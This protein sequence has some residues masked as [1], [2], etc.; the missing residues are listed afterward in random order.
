M[1]AGHNAGA[2]MATTI[3][4]GYDTDGIVRDT[5]SGTWTQTADFSPNQ[6]RVEFHFTDDDTWLDGDNSSDETGNDANQTAIVY[7]MDGNV[8]AS[9][10]VYSEEYYTLEGPGGEIIY[11]DR[12][13][14]GGVH[15]GYVTSAPLEPG[16]TYT[17]TAVNN[18]TAPDAEEYMYLANVPCFGAGTHLLTPE[19]EVPVD[20]LA[21]GDRLVTRDNGVQP[22]LW[23]GRFRVSVPQ[24]LSRPQLR[25]YR[26]A[27][28][29]LGPGQPTHDM[30]LSA[31][32]RVLLS[33]YQVELHAGTEEVLA[34]VAHLG[35]SGL[36]SS[37]VPTSDFIFTHV[38]LPAHE[39][40]MANGMWVESLF[41]GEQV[42]PELR[43]RL[44][45]R[46]RRGPLPPG[47]LQTARR[48]LKQHEVAAIL[49]RRASDHLP[50]L[51]RATG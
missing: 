20:W 42:D 3:N 10:Q 32:H 4:I 2:N 46:Y 49:G 19:G 23:V 5:A 29:A 47:H 27:R 24:A 37:E 43:S 34:A 33:G 39:V 36:F 17:E 12:I 35:D 30:Q 25:P 28:D 6:H 14:I 45:D 51:L 40:V 31:Q 38:L 26:I 22:V 21:A 1:L 50:A 13:E 9:G 41:L 16:V 15:V 8:V 11:V 44:P 48:C 7:D 18:T